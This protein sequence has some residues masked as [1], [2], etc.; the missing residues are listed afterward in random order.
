[1][2]ECDDNG[3]I[4][5]NEMVDEINRLDQAKEPRLSAARVKYLYEKNDNTNCFTDDHKEKLESLPDPR[6]LKWL[7]ETVSKL[8]QDHEL[9]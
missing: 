1:M 2:I 5:L 6:M 4:T 7:I 8:K 3:K 9:G